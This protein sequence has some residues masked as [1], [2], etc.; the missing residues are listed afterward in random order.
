MSNTLN[1]E[2]AVIFGA[3]SAVGQALSKIHA[4]HGGS[5]ILVGRNADRLATIAADLHTRGAL[6]VDYLV[7]DLDDFDAHENL[8]QQIEKK[9]SDI[10]KYYFFYG[11]LPDQSACEASWKESQKALTTNFL[12][13]ASLLTLIANKVEQETKASGKRGIV[14]VTSVAGDRGRQS[15]YVYGAAKGGLTLF[16]QGLRNRLYKSACSVTTVKPGFIDTPMTSDIEKSGP[17]WATPEKVAA[18]IYKAA[19]KGKNEIYTPNFWMLIM[20]IIKNI[21]ETIFKRLSL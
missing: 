11:T 10:A 14:V 12:S 9:S 18:D 15:N 4:E 5:L 6:Q 8:M 19:Q 3:T 1:N 16:L 20:L 13:A 21:P 2:V 7:S 17:L